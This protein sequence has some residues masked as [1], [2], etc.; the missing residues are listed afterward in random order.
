VTKSISL[1]M[2][3]PLALINLKET[4]E[5]FVN[6]PE[7]IFDLDYAGHYFRRIKSVRLTIPCVTG[8]YTAV[9][10]TLTLLSNSVRTDPMVGDTAESYRRQE[11]G[12]TRFRDNVGAIQS[13]TT[14]TTTTTSSGQK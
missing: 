9:N 5:C 13:I 2:L 3:D 11:E 12:E 14:T 8:P 1:A 10:C 6:L 4:G 7:E